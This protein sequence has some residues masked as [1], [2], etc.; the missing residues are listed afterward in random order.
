MHRAEN[1]DDPERLRNIVT[2]LNDSGKTGVFPI[3]PRTRKALE[4]GNLSFADNIHCIDPVGYFDMLE[5]ESACDFIVTDSGGVQK[6]AYFFK[7]PCITLRD[8]TEWVE[9][10][11]A[12]AN[13]LV[14]ADGE[15]ITKSMEICVA[16]DW[17]P[18]YGRGDS[19]EKII[20]CF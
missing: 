4:G 3:H 8:E 2:A 15:R 10:I 20:S 9:T 13:V 18:L 19:G 7:K 14:G 5:L 11:K 17:K 6:E 12:G 1:T 16:V